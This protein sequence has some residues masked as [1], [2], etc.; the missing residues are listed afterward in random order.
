MTINEEKRKRVI[1]VI[2]ICVFFA[3]IVALPLYIWFFHHDIIDMFS[4]VKS[5]ERYIL[6][7]HRNTGIITLILA[8]VCQIIICIIPGQPIQFAAG[9]LFN[10]LIA[11]L[12]SIVGGFLGATVTFYLA[13]LLGNDA[14]HLFFGKK[15]IVQ[16]IDKLNSRNGYFLLFAL[17]VIPGFPKDMMCY[18]S[19]LSKIRYVPFIVLVTIARIPGM[20]GS[21]LVGH[22][23]HDQQY[24]LVILVAVIIAL[25][26]YLCVKHKD[27]ILEWG[28][29]VY[30]RLNRR[31]EK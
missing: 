23:S 4:D 16:Y 3:I 10:P 24:L 26:T 27:R 9:Y 8:Q 15:K 22:Y 20:L 19:G 28:D 14:M 13:K 7:Y 6:E 1:A 5:L 18:V 11:L 21:I 25:I 12:T 17:C 2:K 31:Y 29:R 30:S